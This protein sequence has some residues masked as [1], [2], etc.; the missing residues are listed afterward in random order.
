LGA[1]PPRFCI[2]ASCFR[3]P[4]A[5]GGLSLLS[6]FYFPLSAFGVRKAVAK[7]HDAASPLMYKR[8]VP[9]LK[10]KPAHGPAETIRPEAPPVLA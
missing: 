1:V 2:S 9:T 5:S 8:P 10:P 7:E 4:A 3:L 6:A